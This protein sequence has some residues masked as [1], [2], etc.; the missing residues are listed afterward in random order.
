MEEQVPYLITNYKENTFDEAIK[1]VDKKGIPPTLS[2]NKDFYEHNFFYLNDP[3]EFLEKNPGHKGEKT[4]A[5]KVGYGVKINSK[6]ELRVKI[7]TDKSGLIRATFQGLKE[8]E[9]F[10]VENL[11]KIDLSKL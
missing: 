7:Y 1:N 2:E 11:E 9:F 4:M 10:Q 5:I 8:N 3:K 6:N